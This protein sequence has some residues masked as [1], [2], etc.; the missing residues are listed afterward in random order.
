M[1]I[2]ID[3]INEI[4]EEK[5]LTKKEFAQRVINLEPK[6]GTNAE[7][8][9]ER[10]IYLYL[11]GKRELK[12]D[13]IPFIAEVLNIKEQELFT[14]KYSKDFLVSEQKA[15]CEDKKQTLI[16]EINDLLPY[17]PEIMLINF[18]KKAKEIKRITEEEI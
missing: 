2:V 3:R 9:S 6:V 8:P 15:Q 13:L 1:N 14:N 4:L 7:T 5:S 11:Q 12:A 18:V 17:I 16:K 10:T